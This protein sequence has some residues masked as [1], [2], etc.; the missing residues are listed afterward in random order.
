M[1]LKYILKNKSE[2]FNLQLFVYFTRTERQ[3]NEIWYILK[4]MLF[5]AQNYEI[6]SYI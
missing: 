5:W 3:V 1:F 2:L 6:K 4:E